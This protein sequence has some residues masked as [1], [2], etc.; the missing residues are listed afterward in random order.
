MT[1]GSGGQVPRKPT[2]WDDLKD[3]TRTTQADAS[4]AE[5]AAELLYAWDATSNSFVQL[6][7]QHATGGLN[8]YRV[9]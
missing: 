6:T 2:K 3:V 7:V 4:V 9:N 5:G 8:F 1:S